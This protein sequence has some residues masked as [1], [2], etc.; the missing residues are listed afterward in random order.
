MK[1][2]AIYMIGLAAMGTI[3]SCTKNFLDRYPQTTIAPNQFFNTEQDLLLYTNGMISNG[4]FSL[5]GRDNYLAASEQG[6]DNCVTTGAV[7]IKSVLSGTPTAQNISSGWDFSA[8]R[9]ANYFLDNYDKANVPQE[10]KDHYAGIAKYCRAQF[11]YGMVKRYSDLPWYSH[12]FSSP[13]DSALY[14]P[15]DPRALV[16][17]SVMADLEFASN[18]VRTSVPSGTPDNWA[19]K[20]GYARVA[21]YEGTYRKYHPELNLQGTANTFLQKAGDI[22]DSLMV[23]GK[24]VI[25]NTGNSSQDYATLFNS[26]DLSS[27]KEVI[28]NNVYDVS[29]K[30]DGNNNGYLFGTYEQ[31]PSRDLVQTFLMKDGTRFTDIPGYQT[32][33]FVQEFQNRDP[34]MSQILAYPGWVRQPATTAYVQQIS[35]SF[36]GYH[37]LKGYINSTDPN[38]TGGADFPVYRYAEALLVYAEANAELGTL[39]QADLDKSVNLLRSRAGMPALN[40][41]AANGN[42][43]PFMSTQYPDVS[44]A[45]LGVIL[46][47]RRERRVEL[48]FEALRFDDLMRW[49]AG[50]LLTN[51]PQGMYFPGLGQ[52]DLTGDG[53]PDIALI[54]THDPIP[55]PAPKN[56]LGVP[57]IYYNVGTYSDAVTVS[58]QNGI[59]G[60]ATI[61]DT[62]PRQF[63]DPKY[64]YRPVPLTETVLNPNLKQIFGW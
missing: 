40:M 19:V 27:N 39:N 33:Q 61:T 1:K 14:K 52:Y 54:G 42:P 22:A 43:D 24:F 16:M 34:R 21:L 35:N 64:Y 38:I 4:A 50:Q 7:E 53:V 60:G 5:P 63:L 45:N 10:V 58:L 25:Y 48:A 51:I 31:S 55:A 15:R 12:S 2:I 18:H 26:Q 56:S 29:K 37:Q 47:I 59:N 13:T 17:D 20:M 41:A 9:Q 57:L 36:S 8:L 6:S 32:M 46:E 3:S 30:L 44:G 62:R 49:H 28:F 23:S 11:Y